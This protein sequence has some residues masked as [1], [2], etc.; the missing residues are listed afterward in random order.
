M[1]NVVVIFPGYSIWGKHFFGIA[2]AKLCCYRQAQERNL[3]PF[4]ADLQ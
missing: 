3:L 1:L 2:L 4:S